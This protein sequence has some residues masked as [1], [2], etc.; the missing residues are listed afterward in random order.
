[1]IATKDFTQTSEYMLFSEYKLS[2]DKK[3]RDELVEK[4]LYIAQILSKR[5]INR[6]IEYDDI[7]QVAA[8][9]IL[10]AV[11]RFN[12]D[13][14][15]RFATFATPTVLGEIRRYFRDKGNFIRVPRTLYELF[16]KAEKIKRHSEI[17]NMSVHDLS[18]ALNIPEEDI[19]KAYMLGDKAFIESLEYEAYADGNMSLADTLGIEDKQFMMIENK[20]FLDSA[21]KR[22]SDKERELVKLRF[23]D[24]MTQTEISKQWGVSQ[25]YVS[26]LEKTVLKKLRDLYFH[27]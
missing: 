8:M 21:L 6:G 4:Y 24:E 14:G 23:Y 12:P 7:Y 20:D 2:G 13:R 15:V 22:M 10:Y 1:M 26:R 5:F 27:E 3:L 11:E 19:E 25:M 9:G 16:Y 17:L 18:R